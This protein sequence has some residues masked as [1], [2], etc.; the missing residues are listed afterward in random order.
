M[1]LPGGALL[2]YRCLHLGIHP[3]RI[4]LLIERGL[5][6]RLLLPTPASD[7]SQGTA[8]TISPNTATGSATATGDAS[9][10]APDADSANTGTA[11]TSSASRLAAATESLTAAVEPST[12]AFTSPA[13]DA[14]L[15]N[16]AFA[17]LQAWLDGRLT[18]F[19]LPLAPLPG[20][21]LQQQI[22][23]LI[24]AIPRGE[25]RRY[26][27]LGPPRCVARI[28]STNPLPLLLPCHRVIPAGGSL[29]APGRY[30]GGTQL[31]RWLL[32]AE[33]AG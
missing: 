16:E 7:A 14:P 20:T 26:S 25:T 19:D 31:K 24:A 9:D 30:Q 6:C 5:L 2:R 15:A 21:A 3:L 27:E 17:Q 8:A 10:V 12:Q 13:D 22:R 32:Q 29:A 23:E 11:G 4:G 1:M 18:H 28:C 33:S